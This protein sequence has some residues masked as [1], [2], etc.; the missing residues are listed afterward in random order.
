VLLV[1]AAALEERQL[2]AQLRHRDQ[3]GAEQ[4]LQPP[5]DRLPARPVVQPAGQQLVLGAA[6]RLGLG[7]AGVLQPAV[8]V[9]D[10]EPVQPLDQVEPSGGWVAHATI[11]LRDVGG[12]AQAW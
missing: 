10:L 1:A 2:P 8:R 7:G 12:A 3:P 5:A 11:S 6:P 9:G 4:P